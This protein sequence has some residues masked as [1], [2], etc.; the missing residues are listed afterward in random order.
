MSK[1]HLKGLAMR[2][3]TNGA[4]HSVDKTRSIKIYLLGPN[5]SVTVRDFVLA[6]GLM[7]NSGQ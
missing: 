2:T 5:K 1:N 7:T 3:C 4:D 6:R